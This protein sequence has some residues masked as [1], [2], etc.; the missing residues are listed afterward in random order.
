M[1]K[2]R[3]DSEIKFREQK[4]RECAKLAAGYAKEKRF[5]EAARHY[6]HAHFHGS[7]ALAL[8]GAR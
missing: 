5:D 6:G 8:K 7:L 3:L 4:A 1:N 2:I